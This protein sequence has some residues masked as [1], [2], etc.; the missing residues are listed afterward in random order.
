MKTLYG[1][2]RLEQ[3]LCHSLRL[4]LDLGLVSRRRHALRGLHDYLLYLVG[5]FA[6]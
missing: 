6:G 2:I 3:S 4:G 1:L 5:L